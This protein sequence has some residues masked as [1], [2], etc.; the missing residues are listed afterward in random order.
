MNNKDYL[1]L[2]KICYQRIQSPDFAASTILL[3]KL[4]K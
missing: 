3:Q 4:L 2:D 1:E